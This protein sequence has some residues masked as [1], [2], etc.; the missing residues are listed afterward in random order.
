[1]SQY[2]RISQDYADYMGYG[3]VVGR[4]RYGTKTQWIE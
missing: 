4:N 3:Y 1:M 2:R